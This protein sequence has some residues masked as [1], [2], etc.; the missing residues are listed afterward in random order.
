MTKTTPFRKQ[1]KTD[2]NVWIPEKLAEDIRTVSDE[3]G[4][5]IGSLVTEYLCRG[6]GRDPSE[7]G[8]RPQA[9]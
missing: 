7:F 5:S 3:T 4:R 2:L 8:I 9:V 1:A 6:M